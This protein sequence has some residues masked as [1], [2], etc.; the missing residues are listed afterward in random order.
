M[1][2]GNRAPPSIRGDGPRRHLRWASVQRQPLAS[3]ERGIINGPRASNGP[4]GD[5][6][7]KKGKKE[8]RPGDPAWEWP[9]RPGRV[10]AEPVFRAGLC[11]GPR[12]ALADRHASGLICL[13]ACRR[14]PADPASLPVRPPGMRQ[15]SAL[16]P[17]NA[18]SSRQE[19]E[20]DGD[21]APPAPP[22]TPYS[23]RGH[24]GRPHRPPAP[25]PPPSGATK[26]SWRLE[27]GF[28]RAVEA[29]PGH[30]VCSPPAGQAPLPSGCRPTGSGK[31]CP[32]AADPG[33][34]SYLARTYVQDHPPHP[35]TKGQPCGSPPR[36][37][38]FE[39]TTASGCG[40]AKSA[41]PSTT[42]SPWP[43]PPFQSVH[44][45][46]RSSRA[47]LRLPVAPLGWPGPIPT[48]ARSQRQKSRGPVRDRPSILCTGYWR[49]GHRSRA[50]PG[51]S[52]LGQSNELRLR[53]HQPV[54]ADVEEG[55]LRRSG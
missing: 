54:M 27:G 14:S 35:T 23:P 39:A 37:H 47:P 41:A 33:G 22:P 46:R 42:R 12:T 16:P 29:R 52:P 20:L 53:L 13:A 45:R 26:S 9:H 25:A 17:R 19:A 18:P 34:A 24:G 10:A 6:A 7:Q 3:N 5:S 55:P 48:F 50:L 28:F 40:R 31:C 11:H 43:G 44:Q 38:G 15:R 36:A 4:G 8:K 30:D 32:A 51:L 21:P 1:G 2:V 49:G